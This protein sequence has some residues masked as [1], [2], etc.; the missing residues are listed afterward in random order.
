MRESLRQNQQGSAS[1]IQYNTLYNLNQK[2]R[3]DEQR[4]FVLLTVVKFA[5]YLCRTEAVRDCA[6]TC[7]GLTNYFYPI[8][9]HI[10]R[11]IEP[12]QQV[13]DRAI[14]IMNLRHS[15]VD[16]INRSLLRLRIHVLVTHKVEQRYVIFEYLY[17]HIL[18]R[19]FSVYM[20]IYSLLVVS[21]DS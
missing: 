16:V 20:Y 5:T 8:A 7:I 4:E 19:D 17:S 3:Q 21:I 10:V 13:R 18:H 15:L 14:D 11:S 2:C 1:N 9:E 6:I 12:S